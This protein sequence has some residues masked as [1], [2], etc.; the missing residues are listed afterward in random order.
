M[1]ICSSVRIHWPTTTDGSRHELCR[2]LETCCLRPR[3]AMERKQVTCPRCLDRLK[4]LDAGLPAVKPRKRPGDFR[5][6]KLE[7][8]RDEMKRSGVVD[9]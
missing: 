2:S 5:A 1:T 7:R 4:R 6:R 9:V 8:V 3:F